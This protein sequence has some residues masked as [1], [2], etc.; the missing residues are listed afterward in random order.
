M[1]TTKVL[2]LH[3]DLYRIANALVGSQRPRKATPPVPQV[4]ANPQ[5]I[6]SQGTTGS[7]SQPHPKVCYLTDSFQDFASCILSHKVTAGQDFSIPPRQQVLPRRPSIRRPPIPGPS[8]TTDVTEDITKSE[9]PSQTLVTTFYSSIEP[10]IRNIREEDVGFLEYTG[11]EVEPFVM[12]KF[13]VHYS[14]VWEDDAIVPHNA[15]H[16]LKDAPA[17]S[18]LAPQAT[19]DPAMLQ[20]SDLVSEQQGGPLTDRVVISL[21]P[22][23]DVWKGAEAAAADAMEGRP[24]GSGT[25]AARRQRL[26]VTDLEARVRDTMRFH[27]LLDGVV[28]WRACPNNSTSLK[29]S[30]FVLS[31]FL[32]A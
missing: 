30:C 31:L 21:F 4:S 7:S 11:D 17:S 26:S 13:G 23:P 12:P 19:W 2:P 20:D 29:I 27:G 14:E 28:S 24:G 15:L 1:T 6:K 3:C 32:A 18:F 25:A 5:L 10:W 22:I 8:N 16:K 9:A